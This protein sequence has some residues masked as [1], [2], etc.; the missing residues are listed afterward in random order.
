M[1]ESSG[2]NHTSS[3]PGDPS[4]LNYF[5]D[6]ISFNASV[7]SELWPRQRIGHRI[8]LQMNDFL[9]YVEL[10]SGFLS[11]VWNYTNSLLKG[12][13]K[14]FDCVGQVLDYTDSVPQIICKDLAQTYT[15]E[16][17]IN[18]SFLSGVATN[19]FIKQSGTGYSSAGSIQIS[20]SEMI[21]LCESFKRN[22]VS[23]RRNTEI[24]PPIDKLKNILDLNDEDS[25]N[26]NS[27]EIG[28]IIEPQIL[29]F[30]KL[31]YAF[32]LDQTAHK[33]MTKILAII[34][35]VA[36][37]LRPIKGF[38][39]AGSD[40]SVKLLGKSSTMSPDHGFQ[41]GFLTL[42]IEKRIVPL[43]ASSPHSNMYSLIGIWV[44]GLPNM[45]EP[46][47]D[48]KH[49]KSGDK[50]EKAKR[51]AEKEDQKAKI[52][53][54]P[55]VMAALMRFLLSEEIKSRI[56]PREKRGEI[57]AYRFLLINF[58]G[59]AK[60]LPQFLE[61]ELV[62]SENKSS[63]KNNWMLL[64][65]AC[66]VNREPKGMFRPVR[67]KLSCRHDIKNEIE[68]YCIYR[69][70]DILESLQD[71]RSKHKSK[72]NINPN[73]RNSNNSTN[74]AKKFTETASTLKTQH[75]L[76]SHCFTGSECADKSANF[77]RFHQ[78]R[79]SMCTVQ[80][81]SS[82]YLSS[83]N[84]GSQESTEIKK[85]L[86][87]FNKP[88]VQTEEVPIGQI[89]DAEFENIIDS[90]CMHTV[91]KPFTQG[92]QE[93]NPCAMGMDSGEK[94][95]S[96]DYGGMLSPESEAQLMQVIMENSKNIQAMQEFVVQFTK[97]F[98]INKST[99]IPTCLAN[100]GTLPQQIMS[101]PLPSTTISMHEGQASINTNNNSSTNNSLRDLTKLI[102]VCKDSGSY[103]QPQFSQTD[104]S[105]GGARKV[106]FTLDSSK[107]DLKNTAE[108]D[109]I[110]TEES[111]KKG[112]ILI[113]EN[114]IEENQSEKQENIPESI[115]ENMP[116]NIQENIYENIH[117]NTSENI[118]GNMPE[119]E[120][121]KN[122]ESE[123]I[124]LTEEQKI[125]ES[126]NKKEV[127]I[128]VPKII[129][130]TDLTVS[131]NNSES[132]VPKEKTIYNTYYVLPK[133][134]KEPVRNEHRNPEVFL[135]LNER[136]K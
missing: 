68:H 53:N 29:D 116:G 86:T 7:K 42:D 9:P 8:F 36:I 10:S 51:V 15:D 71:I 72:E 106:S 88:T 16:K 87:F 112:G 91:N 80:D 67:I 76:K 44:S 109:Q 31:G 39:I 24:Q 34:P 70:A 3:F 23:H 96:P 21:S 126:P 129:D 110:I 12:A 89:E 75:R 5:S 117:E 125:K 107:I 98:L 64:E 128:C 93:Y 52:L 63:T 82:E 118:Q 119:N 4:V 41:S 22:I 84:I 131:S 6:K 85:S 97:Q 54:N 56:S 121:N 79:P 130:V 73:N 33:L 35:N 37:S 92:Y 100:T 30:V 69:L 59:D 28:E 101:N 105:H 40:L 94:M 61:F 99:T 45:S 102:P 47:S 11:K 62:E 132:T 95:Q 124:K 38:A 114:L 113:G 111:I 18:R 65:G 48:S 26:S 55:K 66:S 127:S 57:P 134:L 122:Q 20:K 32:S 123:E 103:S 19:L 50:H 13:F 25:L 43:E 108:N 115:P 135:L 60:I 14:S 90:T 2:N 104:S 74:K 133:T 46:L 58:S 136:K 49:Q 78:S 1:L 120:E 27:N 77:L 81:P 17:G 83:D